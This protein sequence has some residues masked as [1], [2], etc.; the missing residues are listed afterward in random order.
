MRLLRLNRSLTWTPLRHGLAAPPRVHLQQ[1]PLLAKAV[2][3]FWSRRCKTRGPSRD[4]VTGI[5]LGMPQV[6]TV[7][8]DRRAYFT[9]RSEVLKTRKEGEM[10]TQGSSRANTKSRN[11]TLSLQ[12]E[13]DGLF[14]QN[15][16]PP[17]LLVC[18]R[19]C[20]KKHFYAAPFAA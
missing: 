4:R 9:I 1:R 12:E 19:L 18:H 17:R 3:I 5:W 2:R 6:Q 14:V 7:R 15:S 16:S 10:R 8:Q 20:R 11:T 13:G